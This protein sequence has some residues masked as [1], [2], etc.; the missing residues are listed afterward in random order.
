MNSLASAE[1]L[2]NALTKVE[3][4]TVTTS[5]KVINVAFDKSKN[6]A[7]YEIIPMISSQVGLINYYVTVSAKQANGFIATVYGDYTSL[8]VDFLIKGGIL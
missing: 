7:N 5:E 1:N 3:G 6:N 8:K 2:E 4:G